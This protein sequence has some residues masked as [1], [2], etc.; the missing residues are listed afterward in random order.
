MPTKTVL[1]LQ[2]GDEGKGKVVDQLVESWADI[3][4]RFQGGDNAGHT[5][6]DEHGH[7]YVLHSL[8]TGVLKNKVLNIIS[9]GCV[10]NP[11]S[12][13]KEIK[14]LCVSHENLNISSGCPAILPHHIEIDKAKYQKKIGT[15]ARGIGPTYT[16][17]FSR[18]G[19]TL[20]DICFN[21][22]KH[23]DFIVKQL[24]EATNVKSTDE[25]LIST[26]KDLKDACL[27][28]KKFLIDDVEDL[29]Q[30]AYQS[31]KN[32]VLE[33]AQGWGLDIWS[34][35]YPNVTCSSPS[36]GGA[37][38]STGLNHQQ[39]DEVIGIAKAYKTR[40]GT[41]EFP[42]ELFGDD[43]N[44]VRIKLGEY[45]ATTSRPRRIGWIDLDELKLACQRN[46]INH[47]IITRTD[48]MEEFPEI[49][50]K[51][52]N[53]IKHIDKWSLPENVENLKRFI[54][55]VSKATNVEN[56]SYSYGPKRNQIAWFEESYIQGAA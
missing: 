45:G 34:D 53:Q 11:I 3:V 27:Y 36:I 4:V 6:Y 44:K 20:K 56:I 21:F 37:I 5:I 33:G 48:S 49:K 7:K 32:I 8:P 19:L 12:I 54:S 24:Q 55:I 26:I 43:I 42:T 40:V 47:L 23:K 16:E 9:R 31:Q 10:V 51:L 52:N 28:L 29:L 1:G 46:G 15:R 50:Y 38:V 39:I 18:S 41:G 22:D 30:K 25:N 2:Y 35:F 14:R 17:Y 13:I